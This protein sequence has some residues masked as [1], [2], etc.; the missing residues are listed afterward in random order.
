MRGESN[1]SNKL[2]FIELKETD[3]SNSYINSY[4]S[5]FLKVEHDVL[6]GSVLGPLLF[7]LYMYVISQK[8]FKR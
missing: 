4:T 6:K 2:Q 8:M 1:L 5:Y 7:L 3:C